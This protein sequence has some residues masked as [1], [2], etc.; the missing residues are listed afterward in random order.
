MSSKRA[1]LFISG[2]VQGVWYRAFTERTATALGL[3]GW[4]RNLPDG[5]VEAV[6]EGI[7]E[8]IELAVLECRKGPQGSRVENVEVSLGEP[9]GEFD[10]FRITD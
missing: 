5:R 4:V 6:M 10:S 7:Q 2:R 8:A 3:S 1:H 9:T